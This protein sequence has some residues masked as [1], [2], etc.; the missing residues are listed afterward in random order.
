MAAFDETKTKPEFNE[1]D[2]GNE[3]IF[4]AIDRALYEVENGF[5]D[6][7]SSDPTNLSEVSVTPGSLHTIGIALAA[8][9]VIPASE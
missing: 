1:E 3:D 8:S 7:L 6:A 9:P 2:S 5:T 4:D